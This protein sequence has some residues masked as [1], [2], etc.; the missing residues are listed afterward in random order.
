MKRKPAVAGQ[1]Y[2]A[3]STELSSQVND[4]I[5]PDAEKEDA[6]GIVSPHAGL[7]YSGE[8]AGEVYSR[9]RKPHTVILLGPNHTGLGK[10]M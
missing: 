1:F 9:I 3:S 5:I 7:I 6:I 4:F 2:P 10:C 8:V